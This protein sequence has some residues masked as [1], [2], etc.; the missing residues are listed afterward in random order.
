MIRRPPRSTRT[1]TLF[2]YTTLFRS[3]H[4][5]AAGIGAR[6]K[7]AARR[8]RQQIATTIASLVDTGRVLRVDGGGNPRSQLA[9]LVARRINHFAPR[10]QQPAD[11]AATELRGHRLAVVGDIERATL[12][13]R[14]E[15]RRVG[16]ECVRTFR[17]Q[18]SPEQ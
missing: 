14:S 16:K 9:K 12:V 3:A 2:P 6:R 10:I 4:R 1:D 8:H 18:W 11:R 15:E 5:R 7:R 13:S 17:S